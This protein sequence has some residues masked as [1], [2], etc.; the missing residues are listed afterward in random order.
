[1]DTSLPVLELEDVVV[2]G[3]AGEYEESMIPSP[4]PNVTR[5]AIG[6]SGQIGFVDVRV[7]E[8][9]VHDSLGQFLWKAGRRGEGPGE[10]RGAQHLQY[11]EDIGWMV[12]SF[13][14]YLIYSVDGILRDTRSVLELPFLFGA[15][16]FHFF[17]SG[18]LW[19]RHA[20]PAFSGIGE[21]QLLWGN[22]NTLE[23]TEIISG[24]IQ[25]RVSQGGKYYL[26]QYPFS[27]A[28][29]SGGRA[30]VNSKLEYEIEILEPG[31]S[32]HWRVRLDH[33]LHRYSRKERMHAQTIRVGQIGEN[34]IYERLTKF[35]PAI[36]GLN[37]IGPDQLWVFTTVEVDSP[38]VQVD[39]FNAE[40]IYQSSFS[41]DASLR[42][43]RISG[44]VLWRLD[45]TS[46]GFPVLIQSRYE[47]VPKSR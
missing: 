8:V 16:R 38:M 2:I 47:V 36:Q 44:D 20:T 46:D 13:E 40:G 30:W 24:I 22:W 5:I 25:E 15:S 10:F 39:V 27:M 12:M 28:Y 21:W 6:P 14:K 29:D 4:Y 34:P 43:A 3:G 32:G 7:P 26:F 45:E 11:L 31:N 19:Y 42:H 33:K 41:A 18:E 35:R 17:P 1:V 9:C 37:W 23:S